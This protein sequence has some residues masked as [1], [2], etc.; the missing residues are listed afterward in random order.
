MSSIFEGVADIF[1]GSYNYY[2]TTKEKNN[3]DLIIEEADDRLAY[4]KSLTEIGTLNFLVFGLAYGNAQ[5][6][7]DFNFVN[8]LGIATISSYAAMTVLIKLAEYAS[9]FLKDEAVNTKGFQSDIL[10]NN[11]IY[12]N[13]KNE[14]ELSLNA[15]YQFFMIGNNLTTGNKLDKILLGMKEKVSEYKEKLRGGEVEKFSKIEKFFFNYIQKHGSLS[16]MLDNFVKDSSLKIKANNIIRAHADYNS[17]ENEYFRSYILQKH[18]T[19]QRDSDTYNEKLKEVNKDAIL[20][21]YEI[22]RQQNMQLFFAKVL[23]DYNN[24]IIHKEIINQFANLHKNT[25]YPQKGESKGVDIESYK[26]ISEIAIR[27]VNNEK[28]YSPNTDVKVVL[29]HINP[30]LVSNKKIKIQSFN[31]LFHFIKRDIIEEKIGKTNTIKV[32]E[33]SEVK[34]IF[35]NELDIDNKSFN[36][37][38]KITEKKLN[39]EKK[40]YEKIQEAK[41]NKI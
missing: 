1:T 4:Y 8:S 26:N 36:E 33:G 24:G 6:M 34:K 18:P 16:K 40:V 23:L 25:K 7:G 9:V 19:I 3:K 32:D 41:K 17:T 2:K 27:M 30:N 39:Q 13:V 22:M 28:I 5:K 29:N 38:V 20:Q 35:Y 21:S 10:K 15:S 31:D 11:E 37:I 14:T 12:N